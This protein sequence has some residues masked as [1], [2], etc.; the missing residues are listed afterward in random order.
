MQ[1][2]ENMDVQEIKEEV[3]L[4]G[5]E[6]DLQEIACNRQNLKDETVSLTSDEVSWKLFACFL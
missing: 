5:D 6:Y 4:S 2:I 1:Q 3:D